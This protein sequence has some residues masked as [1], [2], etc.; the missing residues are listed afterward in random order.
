MT[1]SGLSFRSQTRP[2]LRLGYGCV[3]N[4]VAA[5]RTGSQAALRGCP[6]APYGTID[7]AT[8]RSCV[9]PEPNNTATTP[10]NVS[11]PSAANAIVDTVAAFEASRDASTPRWDLHALL[12]QIDRRLRRC[13][14]PRSQ[15]LCPRQA[16][17]TERAGHD[18]RSLN[19]AGGLG[20]GLRLGGAAGVGGGAFAWPA[21]GTAGVGFSATIASGSRSSV[22]R[23]FETR[24][25]FGLCERHVMSSG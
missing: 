22:N 17:D 19:S 23:A 12:S 3:I 20:S 21:T 24:K 11:A 25:R 14:A 18:A 9:S 16:R 5:V 6:G 15:S 4:D 13:T 7:I 8:S 1:G 10:N 2:V